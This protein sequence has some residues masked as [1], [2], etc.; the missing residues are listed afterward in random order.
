M[1]YV[2]LAHGFEDIEAI[3]VIDILRRADVDVKTVSVDGKKEVV[4]S[5]GVPMIA[6]M[7]IED[8]K[9]EDIDM[10]VL[11]GGMPCT[12]N[13]IS[14]ERLGEVIKQAYADG[15]FISAISSAPWVLAH[16]GIIAGRRVVSHPDYKD[17]LTDAEILPEIVVHDGQFITSKGSGTA[18]H[19]AY[20]IVEVLKGKNDSDKVRDEMLVPLF[21]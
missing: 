1:V 18:L 8:V 21:F 19:F 9:T 17:K 7:L 3:S 13:L 16:L 4:S 20:K 6:D 10:I 14:C 2:I 15:K 11:P 12:E 5:Y